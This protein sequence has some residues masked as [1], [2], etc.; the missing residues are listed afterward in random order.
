MSHI[1]DGL[2]KTVATSEVLGYDHELD[3]RGVWTSVTPGA[4]TY[5]ARFG[6]NAAGSD[7][8]NDHVV[9]CYSGIP[10]TH[11]LRCFGQRD[12]G[13][14]YASARSQHPGGVVAGLGD[15]SVRF[16]PDDIDLSIW[17]AMST[18]A[19]GEMIPNDPF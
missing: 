16:F 6:P 15:A 8:R 12:D 5:V 11:V 4:S 19:G 3:V 13:S 17:R 1:V 2:S 14:A 18:R 9:G 7:E 10:A